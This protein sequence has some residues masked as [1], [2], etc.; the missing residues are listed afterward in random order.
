M[1]PVAVSSQHSLTL[2][3]LRLATK[4]RAAGRIDQNGLIG[5]GTANDENIVDVGVGNQMSKSEL[6]FHENSN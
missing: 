2:S 1:I 5:G 3:L 4:A 6:S